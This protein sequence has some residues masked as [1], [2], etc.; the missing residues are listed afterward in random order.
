MASKESNFSK[1]EKAIL[2]VLHDE[3]SS[4]KIKKIS[5]KS[6]LSWITTRK[7]LDILVERGWIK[8]RVDKYEEKTK[9]KDG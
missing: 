4:M 1:N 7:Y 5:E 6:G 3:R 9:G 2:K 8:K